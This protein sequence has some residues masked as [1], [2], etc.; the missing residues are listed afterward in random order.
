MPKTEYSFDTWW[1]FVW[2]PQALF[3]QHLLMQQ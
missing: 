3:F 1:K 2:D